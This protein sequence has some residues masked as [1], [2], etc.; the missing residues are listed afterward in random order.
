MENFELLDKDILTVSE[1]RIVKGKKTPLFGIVLFLVGLLI[2]GVSSMGVIAVDGL[3][4]FVFSVGL[5]LLVYGIVKMF[6]RGDSFVAP[7]FDIKLSHR[8][9]IFVLF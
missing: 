6:V 1:G 5:V 8:C 4:I 7:V 9:F 3:Q 2:T